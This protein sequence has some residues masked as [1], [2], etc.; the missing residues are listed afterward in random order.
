MRLWPAPGFKPESAEGTFRLTSWLE[1]TGVE[2]FSVSQQ[3]SGNC[4]PRFGPKFV[5][6]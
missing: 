3:I 4:Q 5:S 1:S 2:L 6:A